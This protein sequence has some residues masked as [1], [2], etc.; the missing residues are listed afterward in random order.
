MTIEVG[1]C[2]ATGTLVAESLALAAPSPIAA[3]KEGKVPATARLSDACVD[4][5]KPPTNIRHANEVLS[6]G[7]HRYGPDRH[8]L[9]GLLRAK[10]FA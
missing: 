9:A 3:A 8:H 6:A 2:L 10:S 1:K 5:P 7:R 4:P